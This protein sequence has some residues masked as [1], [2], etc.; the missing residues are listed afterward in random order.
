MH[1]GEPLR[2]SV[3]FREFLH[4]Q[5]GEIADAYRKVDNWQWNAIF[6]RDTPNVTRD[7]LT[8][9]WYPFDKRAITQ[10]GSLLPHCALPTQPSPGAEKEADNVDPDHFRMRE[11]ANAIHNTHTRASLHH[12]RRRGATRNFR[13]RR[14]F[15]QRRSFILARICGIPRWDV[16]N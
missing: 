8:R 16:Y 13:R 6:F 15:R 12:T 3:Q 7:S 4:A 2:A 5:T 1:A 11:R 10:R 9:V 14:I